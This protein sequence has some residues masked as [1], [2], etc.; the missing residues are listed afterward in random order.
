MIGPPKNPKPCDGLLRYHIQN[1]KPENNTT[2]YQSTNLNPSFLNQN[3]SMT[4]TKHDTPDTDPRTTRVIATSQPKLGR[5]K[6]GWK[7]QFG[8]G[9]EDYLERFTGQ[10]IVGRL[11]IVGSMNAT[12]LRDSA[13]RVSYSFPTQEGGF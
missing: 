13:R 2:S 5:D 8:L 11:Y 12:A 9:G 4:A 10:R 3:D 1:P 6:S 7:G